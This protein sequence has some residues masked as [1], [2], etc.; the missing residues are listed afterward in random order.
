MGK[1][2]E[3]EK[4]KGDDIQEAET[5]GRAYTVSSREGG[6]FFPHDF[7]T[8]N[9]ISKILRNVPTSRPPRR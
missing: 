1:K 5:I 7:T 9:E 4:N 8:E 6:C 2:K 3:G